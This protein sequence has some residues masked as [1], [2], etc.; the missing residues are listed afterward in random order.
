MPFGNA[1]IRKEHAPWRVV[2]L[3]LGPCAWGQ[4]C[5]GIASPGLTPT[6][7]PGVGSGRQRWAEPLETRRAPSRLGRGVCFPPPAAVWEVCHC[8]GLLQT[9]TKNSKP[10]F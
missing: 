9:L 6:V 1:E 10:Q 8:S 2:S 5:G 3:G 4:E 7:G